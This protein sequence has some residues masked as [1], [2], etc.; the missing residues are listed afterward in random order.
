[1]SLELIQENLAYF[2]GNEVCETL[3]DPYM[4]VASIYMQT[5]KIPEAIEYLKKGEF[6]IKALNGDIN[7]K[8][9]EIYTCY[10]QISMI[11]Q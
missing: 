10:I 6:V 8:M 2:D 7:E 3:V 5:N 1:M 11:Q 9:L 4:I